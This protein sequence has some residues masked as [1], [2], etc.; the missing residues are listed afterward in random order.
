MKATISKFHFQI[1][2][3]DQIA[4]SIPMVW[5]E[6]TA[7]AMSKQMQKMRFLLHGYQAG[8]WIIKNMETGKISFSGSVN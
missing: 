5:N 3:D 2:I 6:C 7:H 4:E 1:I 8:K